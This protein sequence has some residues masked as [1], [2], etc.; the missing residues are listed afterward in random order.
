MAFHVS[1]WVAESY[2][3]YM[4]TSLQLVSYSVS[5]IEKSMKKDATDSK[6]QTMCAVLI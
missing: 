1:Q 2:S 5:L 6:P 4:E 3:S